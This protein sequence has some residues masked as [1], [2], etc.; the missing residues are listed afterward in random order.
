APC[1][2]VDAPALEI[3]QVGHDA[4]GDRRRDLVFS[5][6]RCQERTVGTV[7]CEPGLHENGGTPRRGEHH[8]A[9]L[10]DATVPTRVDGHDLVL[11]ELGEAGR[12]AQVFI[13]LEVLQDVVERSTRSPRGRTFEPR[14]VVLHLGD[15][16]LVFG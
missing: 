1:R 15:A 3:V 4:I 5:Q 16:L 13:E 2:T 11:L 10:L 7:G 9:R 6:A 12:Y 8:E 14:R